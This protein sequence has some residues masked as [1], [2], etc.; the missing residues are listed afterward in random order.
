MNKFWI[1]VGLLVAI[2]ITLL[3]FQ[4]DINLD[5]GA[6]QQELIVRDLE[7]ECI[8]D[9]NSVSS[10]SLNGQKIIFEGN[11]RENGTT[12][13]LDYNYRRSGDQITLNIISEPS[14]TPSDY[15]NDCQVSI[16]YVADTQ[17]LEPGTYTVTVQHNGEEAEKQ[18]ISI[19]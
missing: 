18:V 7:T 6:D 14:G 4:T 3:A 2:A 5:L 9:H 11:Y 1:G 17:R 12:A 8:Q 15:W 10:I 16:N 19:E 13:D